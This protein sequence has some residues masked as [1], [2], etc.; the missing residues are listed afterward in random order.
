MV[1]GSKGEG[2][3]VHWISGSF[4]A[5]RM[6]ATNHQPLTPASRA[7]APHLSSTDHR[8]LTTNHS[9]VTHHVRLPEMDHVAGVNLNERAGF[10]AVPLDLERAVGTQGVCE[11]L[12]DLSSGQADPDAMSE[13]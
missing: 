11:T 7:R 8:P 2:S 9:P 1:D 5:L 4:A 6:T 3:Q 13:R 10:A 12:H